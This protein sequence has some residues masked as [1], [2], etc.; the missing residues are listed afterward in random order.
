MRWVYRLV[1]KASTS[2]EQHLDLL[3]PLAHHAAMVRRYKEEV[4]GIE[5]AACENLPYHDESLRHAK[6][7]LAGYQ[8]KLDDAVRACLKAGIVGWKIRLACR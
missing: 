6:R 8:T 7:D 1:L 5:A 3:R 4:A 2:D